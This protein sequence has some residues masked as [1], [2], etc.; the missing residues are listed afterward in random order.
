MIRIENA[1]YRAAFEPLLDPG[2]GMT[3]GTLVIQQNQDRAD[4]FLWAVAQARAVT[5]LGSAFAAALASY[6]LSR[7]ITRPVQHW[8]SGIGSVAAGDF[9]VTFAVRG[10]DELAQLAAAFNHMVS[11]LVNRE[12]NFSVCWVKPRRERSESIC[13]R[14]WRIKSISDS[15]CKAR[16]RCSIRA[17]GGCSRCR[18]SGVSQYNSDQ[19]L[20]EPIHRSDVDGD[21]TAA[22]QPIPDGFSRL[23]LSD[24]VALERF[25]GASRSVQQSTFAQSSGGSTTGN[26]TIEQSAVCLVPMRAADRLLGQRSPRVEL[27]DSGSPRTRSI[28][29]KHSPTIS[30]SRWPT[31]SL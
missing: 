27:A 22:V 21:A 24:A 5:I 20:L 25:A 16:W 30:Q 6:L 31:A 8:P 13:S 17:L 26:S 9:N 7:A 15:T 14:N 18:A 12:P 11:R 1:S 19:R 29:S 2:S 3:V 28:S 4:R 23:P 10:N